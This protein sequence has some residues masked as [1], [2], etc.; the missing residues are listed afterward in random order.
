MAR[1]ALVMNHARR[2]LVIEPVVAGIHAPFAAV[3][4]IPTERQLLQCIAGRQVQECPCVVAGAK[5]KIDRFLFDIGVPAV[6][7]NLPAPLVEFAVALN[8]LEI[9]VRRLV[10]KGAAVLD[11]FRKILAC[12]RVEGS[13][14][15]S[16]PKRGSDAF[17]APG[18]NFRVCVATWS[19][20]LRG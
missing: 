20:I 17:V 16:L 5:N 18:A 12:R 13:A 8:V 19:Q 11:H 4:R 10:K 14:H 2:T 15:A 7:S 6:E 1:H 9:T 3:F